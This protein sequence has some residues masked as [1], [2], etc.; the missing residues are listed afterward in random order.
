[1]T[2]RRLG[3]TR[4]KMGV[5]AG[6]LAAVLLAA[7]L[8]TLLLPTPAGAE[9]PF[10]V[11]S[12]IEDRAA[13]LG[14]RE[15]DV[16]AAIEELQDGEQV[17][18]W[19]TFV[20][21]FSGVA[22]QDWANETAVQSDLGLRDVLLAVAVQDR[23]YAYSVE[24]DFPLS[25]EQLDGVMTASVEPRLS[26]DDWAGA[27]IGAADGI[28]EA[29][30]GE[31][32][33][34]SSGGGSSSDGGGSSFPWLLAIGAVALVAVIA[35]FFVRARSRR[36]AEGVPA[37]GGAD[38]LPL[39]ELRRRAN[40]E[41]VAADDAVKTSAQELDFAVAE[42]G[43][44]P[45]APFRQAL[46]EARGD[47]A[48]AFRLRNELRDDDEGRQRE[49]LTAILQHTD[50]ANT[51]LDAQA[52]RFDSLRDL[53]RN[54]PEVLAKLEGQL[55]ELEARRPQVVDELAALAAGYAPA[56]L[57]AV[58]RNPDEAQARI[59]FAR[60]QI[61]LGREDLAA[62]RR[63]EAAVSA[64]A[65]QEATGQAQTLLDA[66]GRLRQE[67]QEAGARIA[68]AVA[69]TRRDIAEA[70]ALG[71]GERLAPRIAGAEAALAAAG[72][73][74]A[75]A[76]GRDPLTALR[77]LEEA[78]AS[79]EQA[80]VGVRDEQARVARAAEVLDR[81]LLAARSEVASAEDFITTHRG[82]VGSG[83]R[84]LLAGAQRSLDQAMALA[85]S[86]PVTAAHHAAQAQQQAARAL[87]DAS[88]EAQQGAGMGMPGMP[89][90]PGAGRSG[91]D[92]GG[93]IIG[94]ILAGMLGGGGFGGGSGGGR[95]GGFG[96]GGFGPPSFGGGGTR[97]R[98]GGGG[99][100]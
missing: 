66:V 22:A 27:A 71:A 65:A 33:S 79:L 52:D 48:E 84:T 18:L 61:R 11:G 8:M 64:L 50:A 45:A 72:E 99:R 5:L 29:L 38:V 3:R 88:D 55:T 83:P 80:L 69:E 40:A 98:R 89:G 20:D 51:V 70:Q 81:T 12:Q 1:M 9:Q 94:G 87:S 62:E 34:A 16:W 13:V 49:I 85:S 42:F 7:A 2:A 91:G 24:Q 74:A 82:A 39:D 53:E 60:E 25:Q 47:V 31:A 6:A 28:G 57:L 32:A 100:F 56:A 30:R 78:D 21:T 68:D 26:D 23:A 17:Q 44:E 86:D 73:A 35:W 43:E 92:I 4:V 14:G 93:M 36:A 96:G 19:V 37:T 58:R 54:A 90:M 15:D 59:D 97:M 41:L 67:L 76:G 77:H 63:G 46:E 10:R 95:S 75:A